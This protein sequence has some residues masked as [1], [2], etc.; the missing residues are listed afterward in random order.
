M[1]A[2]PGMTEMPGTAPQAHGGDVGHGDDVMQDEAMQTQPSVGL[3]V[4]MVA[5]SLVVLAAALLVVN[6]FLR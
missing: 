3:R 4:A 5:V 1:A 2:M 6:L